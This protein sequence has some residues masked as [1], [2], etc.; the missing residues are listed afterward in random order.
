MYKMCADIAE[1][2]AY[3]SK[4]K[5]VHRDLAARNC[6]VNEELQVKIGDFGLTRDV[7]AGVFDAPAGFFSTLFQNRRE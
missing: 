2:M 6:L 4:I 5:I 3:L 7:Y 1:G